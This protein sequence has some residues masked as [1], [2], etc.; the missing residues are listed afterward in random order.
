MW[1]DIYI[2][3]KQIKSNSDDNKNVLDEITFHL[4]LLFA[5]NVISLGEML[6]KWVFY[7]PT[8]WKLNGLY[9]PVV[10]DKH[11]PGSIFLLRKLSHIVLFTTAADTSVWKSGR[12]PVVGCTS[13]PEVRSVSLIDPD[14]TL[15]FYKKKSIWNQHI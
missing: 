9:S 13:H 7:S 10:V 3:D 14:L 2:D 12:R 6:G 8:I 1:F 5:W 15:F 11:I 4:L